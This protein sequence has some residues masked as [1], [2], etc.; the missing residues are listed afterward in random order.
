[1]L[2]LLHGDT[3]FLGTVCATEM[4]KDLLITQA[5]DLSCF[6]SFPLLFI[7]SW[8]KGETIDTHSYANNVE[9]IS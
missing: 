4:A 6:L 8:G 5:S 9:P 2:L 1:M 7:H 3:D